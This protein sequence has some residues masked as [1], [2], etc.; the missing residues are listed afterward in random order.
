MRLTRAARIFALGLAATTWLYLTSCGQGTNTRFT[1]PDAQTNSIDL[2]SLILEKYQAGEKRIVIPPGEYRLAKLPDDPACLFFREME[3][4][5]IEATGVTFLICGKAQS[6]RLE[7]CRNITLKGATFRHEIPAFSQGRIERVDE[8]RTW[9]DVRV[10]TGY[11]QEL[12]DP[13]YFFRPGTPKLINLYDPQTRELK[14]R[15]E[16]LFFDRV[17]KLTPGLFRFYF[18]KSIAATIPLQEGDLACWRGVVVPDLF[19]IECEG[20]RL[21][22]VTIQSGSGFSIYEA[23]GEGGNVYQE[24][25]IERGPAPKGATELPLFSSNADGFHS[26]SVRRGPVLENCR[27]TH[28]NDDCIAIHGVAYLILEAKGKAIIAASAPQ[29]HPYYNKVGDTIRLYDESG[30]PVGEATLEAV[31]RLENYKLSQDISRFNQFE[32]ERKNGSLTVSKM[33]LDREYSARYS[34]FAVN[35]NTQG[36]GFVIRNCKVGFNRP[37]GMLIQAG[38]GIIEGCTVEGSAIG[39]IIVAPD[40]H[41]WAEGDYARNLVIR[42][43]VL[44]SVGIWNQI[45]AVNVSCWWGNGHHKFT[46]SGGHR[47]IT[48]EGNTFEN[49]DGLNLLVSSADTVA[50]RK[51]RFIGPAQKFLDAPFGAPSNALGWITNSRHAMVEENTVVNPGAFLK[52]E[53]IISPEVTVDSQMP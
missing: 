14:R 18:T 27:F 31:A 21:I 16:D 19:L 43:N 35:A 50:I 46:P 3:N 28:M 40:M 11:L 53:L 41:Y 26:V 30:A 2:R 44:R 6:L 9:F 39:G 8:K 7:K 4:F 23:G 52:S 51:N 42:N 37:R 10:H 34:W 24:C 45:G 17:E 49:N 15:A 47:N 20:L 5:E 13:Q 38:D 29:S 22:Q 32:I 12:D 25:R 48:I 1:S 33:L 36:S